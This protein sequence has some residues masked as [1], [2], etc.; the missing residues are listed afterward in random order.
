MSNYVQ[1][2]DHHRVPIYITIY[3]YTHSLIDN[4]QIYTKCNQ[5][6]ELERVDGNDSLIFT[7]VHLYSYIVDGCNH[8]NLYRWVD[9]FGPEVGFCGRSYLRHDIGP[10]VLRCRCWT[11]LGPFLL[12]EFQKDHE[13]RGISPFCL[14]NYIF[15]RR[16]INCCC[17]I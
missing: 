5:L 8:C 14:R 1:F 10:T 15:R 4:T 17:T 6:D 12:G 16:F 11:K 3:I 9:V 13:P 2:L 7:V